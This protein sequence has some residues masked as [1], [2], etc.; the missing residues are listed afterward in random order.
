[1]DDNGVSA[2]HGGADLRTGAD[3]TGVVEA[4]GAALGVGAPPGTI[5]VAPNAGFLSARLP[6]AD[7]ALGSIGALATAIDRL[8]LARKLPNRPWR[9]D[10]ER[11]AASFGSDKLIRI[12]GAPVN[13]FA[14]LS[15]FFAT[16]DGWIRTHANY[17]HHHRRLLT[18]LDLPD[19]SVAADLAAAVA[20]L[21][22]DDVEQRATAAGA[23][24]VRVR[25]ESQWRASMPETSAPIVEYTATGSI[26]RA[27]IIA[28]DPA[29]PLAGIRVLDLTRVLAGPVAGRDLALLGADVL[30]VDPPQLPEIEWQHTLTGEGKR[31]TRL[32][33]RS[34]DDHQLFDELLAGA[35][36]LLTGYRPGALETWGV[37]IERPGL[38]HGSVCAHDP[39]GPRAGRRGFDSLVQAA[40]GISLIEGD[41]D[42]P[43][44]LPVQALDHASGHLLAAGVIDALARRL[45]DGRGAQV[46]VILERTAEYLLDA[47][48]RIASAAPARIPGERTLVT[49]GGLTTERPALVEYDTY[50]FAA[51]PLGGDAPRWAQ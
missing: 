23:L 11:V 36:V 17:P 41:A 51:R 33:L 27:A 37:D 19:N 31:S 42:R 1:M 7:L 18:V 2:I 39:R 35:D 8:R 46:A 45:A 47:P 3:V 24:A 40:T 20:N 50:P 32:D 48:G 9:L 13:G 49:T 12:D 10:P 16:A 30:R 38:V 6:V 44:A 15:G 43:G 5:T 26:D 34:S 21:S 14:P 29:L 28:D 22:A 4:Y 25:T